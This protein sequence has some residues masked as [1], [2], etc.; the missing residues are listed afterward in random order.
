MSTEYNKNGQSRLRRLGRYG[1]I[2]FDEIHIKKSDG[3]FLQ[4]DESYVLAFLKNQASMKER[5]GR[6]RDGFF[7][8]ST[9]TLAHGL[10]LT[11]W[12]ERRILKSLI[13]E[14][15]IERRMIGNPA[16][17]WLKINYGKLRKAI[18]KVKQT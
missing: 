15:F 5:E 13:K 11:E 14:G 17:R 18:K 6:T 8:C 10:R 7:R 3:T 4:L 16:K 9:K 2:N 12:V 1:Y